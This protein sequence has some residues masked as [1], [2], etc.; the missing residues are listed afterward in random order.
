MNK[1]PSDERAEQV[2]RVESDNSISRA[3]SQ[4]QNGS[5]EGNPVQKVD[6]KKT[7]NFVE[8]LAKH[9][10]ICPPLYY[11]T[12]P[13][14]I[15]KVEFFNF[16][17]L[18]VNAYYKFD[19]N[20]ARS[21]HD[22]GFV[23]WIPVVE[24]YCHF[25]P[26][27]HV[28]PKQFGNW[29]FDALA[30]KPADLKL[31][32]TSRHYIS[33]TLEPNSRPFFYATTVEPDNK[34][35]PVFNAMADT[36]VSATHRFSSYKGV[37]FIDSNTRGASLMSIPQDQNNIINKS[38][39]TVNCID[40]PSSSVAVVQ[41][42]PVQVEDLFD[43]S[44]LPDA[45]S[46]LPQLFGLPPSVAEAVATTVPVLLADAAPPPTTY[47][48]TIIDTTTD[49]IHYVKISLT[50]TVEAVLCQVVKTNPG[51]FVLMDGDA[52]LAGDLWKTHNTDTVRLVG[53]L[54]NQK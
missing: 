47:K 44:F 14:N 19:L 33:T 37:W 48:L 27:Y 9:S 26:Q 34:M 30:N 40:L 15:D 49:R 10:V 2:E 32:K 20:T 23:W 17:K 7:R 22:K 31:F 8:A 41:K 12:L 54:D 25:A 52:I 45:L 51:D 43:L 42:P 38:Q 53:K 46:P 16:F 36:L 29:F 21:K 13:K 50:S 24:F 5:Q 3:G 35:D 4:E 18:F 11:D 28:H 39:A 1:E 6:V